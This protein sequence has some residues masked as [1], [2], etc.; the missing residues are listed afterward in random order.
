MNWNDGAYGWIVFLLIA[1]TLATDVWRWLGVFAALRVD[2]NGEVFRWVRAVSNALVAA[3]IAKL[4]LFPPGVLAE[5][6][7]VLRGGAFLAGVV[8]FFTFGRSMILGI[9]LAELVLI[10]GILIAQQ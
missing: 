8:A 4:V 6:S 10:A 3:L 1:G 2:E 5:T 7:I 9:V